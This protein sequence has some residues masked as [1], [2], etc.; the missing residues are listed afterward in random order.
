MTS[1]ENQASSEPKLRGRWR[2]AVVAGAILL[3]A[4]VIAVAAIAAD[5]GTPAPGGPNAVTGQVDPSTAVLATSYRLASGGSIS[6]WTA[7]TVSGHDCTLFQLDQGAA[8]SSSALHSNAFGLCASDDARHGPLSM[9][10]SWEPVSGAFVP[11]VEA[12]ANA[13]WGITRLA[14]LN[15]TEE[16]TGVSTSRGV[17]IGELPGSPTRGSLAAGGPFYLVGYDAAGKEVARLNVGDEVRAG[18]PPQS[19]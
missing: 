1:T 16:L 6:G 18:T 4:A 10:V 13:G 12:A 7:R 11:L 5:R 8:S 3:C 14:L 9:I 15:D 2:R 19:G 17:L